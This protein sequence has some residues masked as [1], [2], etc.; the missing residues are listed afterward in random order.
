LKLE[1]RDREPLRIECRVEA[2]CTSA[3]AGPQEK[4]LDSG[5]RTTVS[6]APDVEVEVG[7]GTYAAAAAAV[8]GVAAAVGTAARAGAS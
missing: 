7:T 5:T 1:V 4:K 3:A 6:A 8:A 2:R